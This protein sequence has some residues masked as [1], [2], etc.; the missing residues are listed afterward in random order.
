MKILFVDD[1]EK[2]LR[3]IRRSMLS[4]PHETF[5]ARTAREGLASLAEN[6]PDVVVSDFLMPE[7]GGYEFLEQ[8]RKASPSVVR[9]MLSGYADE[10]MAKRAL[11]TGVASS[12]L[13]KP[14][15]TQDLVG[16]LER[17][18]AAKTA[19]RD[20]NLRAVMM[21]TG[22]LPVLPDRHRHV[23]ELMEQD[24]DVRDIAVV[25]EGDA[26][27]STDILKLANSAYYGRPG[28]VRSVKEALVRIGL[29][30]AR[31]IVF[32][33]A[34]LGDA[35]LD[36]AARQRITALW[37]HS[38]RTNR[39]MLLFFRRIKQKRIPEV[40]LSMGL[41]HHIGMFFVYA[42]MHE[43]FEKILAQASGD[44][45]VTLVEAERQVIGTT[46]AEIGGYLLDL[47]S[48]PQLLVEAA[49]FHHAPLQPQLP[50][51]DR[52]ILAMLHIADHYAWTT[53]DSPDRHTQ[54]TAIDEAIYQTA[55]LNPDQIE[56]ILAELD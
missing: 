3:S 1:E 41:V 16:V 48:F 33:L 29:L 21:A 56:P 31:S 12:C 25:V 19:I 20:P 42:R 27:M 36:H 2:M 32:S 13:L 50:E 17:I 11:L 9:I 8:A 54:D 47:W 46:H 44:S 4:Y 5:F 38:A 55:E 22:T 28:S 45:A 15:E 6:E 52:M 34:V 40:C 7:V 10:A 53:L 18:H 24:R 51:R 49:L 23:L 39:L 43:Q 37:D 30:S 26:V 35:H 14:I